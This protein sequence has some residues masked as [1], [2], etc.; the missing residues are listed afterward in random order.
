MIC[1]I[2]K[3]RRVCEPVIEYLNNNHDPHTC[4]VVSQESI[5]VIRT[6]VATPVDQEC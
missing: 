3:L 5:K 4:V 6:E 1:E 2:E